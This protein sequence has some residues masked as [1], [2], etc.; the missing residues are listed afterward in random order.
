M[1]PPETNSCFFVWPLR[2]TEA[3]VYYIVN[4]EIDHGS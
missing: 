1:F 2:G 3:C 4:G